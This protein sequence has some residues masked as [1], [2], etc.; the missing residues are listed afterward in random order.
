MINQIK[1]DKS[2]PEPCR[3]CSKRTSA[4]YSAACPA[5]A[6]FGCGLF[7]KQHPEI[8]FKKFSQED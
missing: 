5:Y 2:L 3:D 8:K 6:D 1:R 4:P 7:F